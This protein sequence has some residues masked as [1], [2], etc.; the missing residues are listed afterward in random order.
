M[1][2]IYIYIGFFILVSSCSSMN[3]DNVKIEGV[4][5]DITET[6]IV[7]AQVVVL[8]WKDFG[9][10]KDDVDY[11]KIE[12]YTNEKG[13]FECEF[14]KGYKVDMAVKAI[15]YKIEALSLNVSPSKIIKDTIVLK[16][17]SYKEKAVLY[18]N[19]DSLILGVKKC[20]VDGVDF[21]EEWGVNVEKGINTS[22]KNEAS[23]WLKD[24][25]YLLA[26][27]GGGI[28]PI[29]K[30]T[31]KYALLYG[32][33]KA[34]TS[35]YMQKYKITGQERGYF[36]KTLNDRYGKIILGYHYEKISPDDTGVCIEEGYLISVIYQP[37]A[38]NNLDVA[39]KKDLE[40][41]LLE[42]Y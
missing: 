7:G 9:F 14:E 42:K 25:G 18:V 31:S 20:E 35:G 29:L 22:N 39:P 32:N 3:V 33:T 41:L 8:C 23:V 30:D 5:V 10:L 2:K 21:I 37:D 40:E 34:P 26:H 19:K 12:T 27:E 6:P 15:N 28:I 24:S 16:T 38:N 36:I 17:D 13:A 4:V 1:F 11:Y